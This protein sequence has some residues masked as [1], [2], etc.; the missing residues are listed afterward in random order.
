MFSRA[1]LFDTAQRP[2]GAGSAGHA[3]NGRGV[4][5]PGSHAARRQHI[6]SCGRDGGHQR[7]GAH[8]IS[9]RAAIGDRGST[10]DR[11]RG[12]RESARSG[13]GIGTANTPPSTNPHTI[14]YP[15]AIGRDRGEEGS[16]S[17]RGKPPTGCR[18]AAGPRVLEPIGGWLATHPIPYMLVRLAVSHPPRESE[19]HQDGWN[20]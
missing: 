6:I 16:G 12:D 5:Q 2:R 4:R 11:R 1:K 14:P 19:D 20:W 15:P 9:F 18:P 7:R 17:G 13:S 10:G 8:G 3:S